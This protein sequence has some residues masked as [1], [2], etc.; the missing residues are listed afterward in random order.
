MNLRRIFNYLSSVIYTE[1]TK[2]DQHSNYFYDR[3]KGFIENNQTYYKNDKY[4]IITIKSSGLL[5]DINK[6]EKI[7]DKIQFIKVV[8]E[9]L[10]STSEIIY[11]KFS[12][13]L[14]YICNNEINVVFHG[15]DTLYNGNITKNV[16]T[17]TSCITL[18]FNKNIK[19]N[20]EYIFSGHT[21]QFEKEYET[22]NY[23]IWRYF[24]CVRN[25]SNLLWRCSREQLSLYLNPE[26]PTLDIV[27]NDTEI[28]SD[29]EYLYG[30]LLKKCLYSRQHSKHTRLIL[31]KEIINDPEYSR[32][33]I[34]KMDPKEVF[35]LK[36]SNNM[37]D[38]IRSKILK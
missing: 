37:D 8:N 25:V 13:Y 29:I 34:K 31:E 28:Y 23:I 24:D 20:T 27:K 15:K 2:I 7:S 21:V 38:L 1:P 6:I 12:P 10:I 14:I 22:L 18:E 30:C 3:M 26:V 33:Y 35:S 9:A 19:E 5:D 16:S 36:F 17:I 32:R 11:K 4:Y